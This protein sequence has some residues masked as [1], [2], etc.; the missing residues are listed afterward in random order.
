MDTG[1]PRKT[2]ETTSLLRGSERIDDLQRS[3]LRIIQDPKGNRFSTDAVLLSSYCRAKRSDRV[4][5]LG[6]GTGILTLLV[7]AKWHPRSITGIELDPPTA[8][9]ASRS[10]KLN[11]LEGHIRILGGDLKDAAALLGKASFTLA[12]SNPPYIKHGGGLEGDS[13]AR[14]LAR[15]EI[16]CTFDDVAKA[17]SELLVPAGR[18]ALVHR[19]DRLADIICSLRSWGLEPKNMRMVHTRASEPPVLVLVTSVKGASAGLKIGPSLL[20]YGEDGK[21]SEETNDIYFGE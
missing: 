13:G 21:Y 12:I 19:P 9:M 16:G 6:T 5:D 10:V 8:D 14:A 7:W 1:S 15:H 2:E 17:A 20:I 18:F 4:V 11:G 3:G